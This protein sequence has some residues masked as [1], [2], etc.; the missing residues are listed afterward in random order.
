MDLHPYRRSTSRNFFFRYHFDYFFDFVYLNGIKSLFNLVWASSVSVL[1][2]GLFSD[3]PDTPVFASIHTLFSQLLGTAPVLILL[4]RRFSAISFILG[5]LFTALGLT[6]S[7]VWFFF[8]L[9]WGLGYLL[10]FGFSLIWVLV[11]ARHL[12]SPVPL[13]ALI[14]TN[15]G[16]GDHSSGLDPWAIPRGL[17]ADYAAPPSLGAPAAANADAALVPTVNRKPPF[18]FV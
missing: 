6:F 2:L 11:S 8:I 16:T 14:L 3:G 1:A 4:V 18:K 12:G 5:L 10:L 9:N 7:W 15:V 17:V 13:A